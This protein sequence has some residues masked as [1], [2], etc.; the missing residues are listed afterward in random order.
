MVIDTTQEEPNLET[1]PEQ[2]I[3]ENSYI[4]TQNENIGDKNTL[5]SVNSSWSKQ[6]IIEEPYA[7]SQN[8]NIKEK[9]TS[10]PI[11]LPWRMSTFKSKRR[12]TK[13]L[14]KLS[15]SNYFNGGKD[16]WIVD[17]EG[18]YSKVHKGLVLREVC[19]YNFQTGRYLNYIISEEPAFSLFGKTNSHA[20]F[21]VKN[22]HQIPEHYSTISL[23]RFREIADL[24]T[25]LVDKFVS[26]G[27]DKSKFLSKY[28][29]AKVENIEDYGAPS[30]KFLGEKFPTTRHYCKFH[31]LG[32]NYHCSVYK[33]H[34]IAEYIRNGKKY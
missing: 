25:L 17:F 32:L 26:K 34:L 4:M 18:H 8:E 28:F 21:C 23:A 31:S 9:N 30:Y 13:K 10:K 15:K 5:E 24:F 16:I 29:H 20:S 27:S 6:Q 14:K 33:T 12:K 2:Q 7:M 1:R 3:A 11:D 19:F 22:I